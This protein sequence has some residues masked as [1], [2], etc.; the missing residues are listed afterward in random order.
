MT[1]KFRVPGD[2][3]NELSRLLAWMEG[4]WSLAGAHDLSRH[5]R[6]QLLVEVLLSLASDASVLQGIPG[7]YEPEPEERAWRYI[8]ALVLFVRKYR[9]FPK[10][11]EQG[12][13]LEG[14]IAPRLTGVPE[15]RPGDQRALRTLRERRRKYRKSTS[16]VNLT[17]NDTENSP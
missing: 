7:E 5:T 10:R 6:L 13:L 4:G 16:S 2:E 3:A 1:N 15:G 9:R 8:L 12:L 11:D 14:A 17:F